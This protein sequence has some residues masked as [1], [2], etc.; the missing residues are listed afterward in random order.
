MCTSSALDSRCSSKRN[1]DLSWIGPDHLWSII[2][3]W[4]IDWCKKQ[5]KSERE[6]SSCAPNES[7]SLWTIGQSRSIQSSGHN[8]WNWNLNRNSI[9]E[10]NQFEATHFMKTVEGENTRE[11][12]IN[13]TT[14][15][16][17]SWGCFQQFGPKNQIFH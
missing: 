17:F 2:N 13:K 6:I 16:C 12:I 10:F 3:E 11:I 1:H 5:S 8:A 14:L 4:L 7:S 15:I 9:T